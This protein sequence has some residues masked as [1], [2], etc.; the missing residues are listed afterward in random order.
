[1]KKSFKRIIDDTFDSRGHWDY[2]SEVNFMSNPMTSS[3][4]AISFLQKFIKLSGKAENKLYESIG[5]LKDRERHVV[6]AFFIGHYIYKKSKFKELIDKQI[7]DLRKEANVNSDISFSFIWF[8]TCFFHDLGYTYE[9]KEKP[10]Y[11]TIEKLIKE[12]VELP[13]VNGVPELY[14]NVYKE[15]FAYRLRNNKNDHGITAA[16]I[17]F[18]ELKIIRE[19]AEENLNCSKSELYWG[20]ELLEVYNFIAWNILAHNIWYEDSQSSYDKSY[21]SMQELLLKPNQYKISIDKHP[22]FFLFCLVD[23]IEPY[24]TVQS[25]DLL[26][27]V[28]IDVKKNSVILST[29]LKCGCGKEILR[30]AEDL[31]EWLTIANK[32]NDGSVEINFYPKKPMGRK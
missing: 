12:T 24:K 6:S 5:K 11:D 17:L 18:K 22:F 16:H 25:Y 23:T 31:N 9:V 27:K 15:Y 2:Y 26:K 1:M 14:Q 7:D 13:K 4:E 8:M 21:N 30:K 32:K 20:K 29:S 28:S 3:D 10:E 19:L